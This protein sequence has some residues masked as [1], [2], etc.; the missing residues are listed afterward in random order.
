MRL[1]SGL[2]RIM[3]D[4]EN[5]IQSHPGTRSSVVDMNWLEKRASIPIERRERFLDAITAK[6]K[7][8]KATSDRGVPTWSREE[9]GFLRRLAMRTRLLCRRFCGLRVRPHVILTVLD[10]CPQLVFEFLAST[11][12]FTYRLPARAGKLG[13]L[14][15]AEQK[16]GYE[17]DYHE[18]HA[19]GYRHKEGGYFDHRQTSVPLQLV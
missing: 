2:H 8:S 19:A 5:S 13:E 1:A 6:A 9:T 7:P 15:R 16:D 17:Q 11:F 18:L 4:P 14:V 10:G 12:E 3:A